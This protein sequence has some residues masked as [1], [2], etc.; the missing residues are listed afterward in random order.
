MP[1]RIGPSFADLL[2][3]LGQMQNGLRE[4]A[5]Q[6]VKQKEL[7]GEVEK[8]VPSL[9]EKDARQEKAKAEQLVA[10]KDLDEAAAGARKLAARIVSYLESQHGKDSPE[11]KQYGIAP[12]RHAGGKRKQGTSGS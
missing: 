12:R 2:A 6:D 11:L 8:T 10:S 5:K 3:T 9:R 7:L 1:T 4:G